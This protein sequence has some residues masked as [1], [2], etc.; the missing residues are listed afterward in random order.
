M[1]EITCGIPIKNMGDV[2]WLQLESL[3][4]QNNWG[5]IDWEI[6]ILEDDSDN[7]LEMSEELK[8]RL[9][10]AGCVNIQW[11]R[12][13]DSLPIKWARMGRMS[14]EDSKM[15]HLCGADDW[16]P[17]SR[18]HDALMMLEEYGADGVQY[19]RGN[20]YDIQSDE[21][22][23]FDARNK[24]TNQHT[25]MTGHHISL[26]TDYMRRLPL[27]DT[28]QFGVDTWVMQWA[29]IRNSNLQIVPICKPRGGFCT[30]G[31]N[32]ISNGRAE[33]M[34]AGAMPYRRYSD[35]KDRDISHYIPQH[36]AKRIRELK[37]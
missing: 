33:L 16:S 13:N 23:L 20:M 34:R 24:M 5:G 6:I 21:M 26:R 17:P 27:D 3:A 2:A 8:D 9:N 36:Y 22:F 28:R 30:T 18:L 35:A 32:L 15:F 25:Y 10:E 29:K 37:V 12:C 1:I 11:E 7:P 14:S 19:M 31:R 4:N